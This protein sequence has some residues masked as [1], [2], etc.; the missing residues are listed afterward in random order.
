MT[1][2]AVKPAR[3]LA[4]TAYQKWMEAQEIPIHGGYGVFDVRTVER[5]PWKL[6]GTPGAFIE[7]IGMEGFSGMQVVEI[8][9]GGAILPQKHMFQQ[10]ICGIEG[11]GTAEVWLDEA[12]EQKLTFEWGPFSLFSPPLNSSY[13]LY[14]VGNTPVIYLAVND[15]PMM[16]DLFHNLDFIFNNPYVFRD[17]FTGDDAEYFTREERF[18]EGSGMI[19]DTNF[20][21]DVQNALVDALDAKGAGVK[22]TIFDM[23]KN[24]FA[25]HLTEWPVGRYHKS[26]HHQ[27]GAIL[28]IAR[29]TGYS[30]MWPQEL[31]VRPYEN[32]FDDQI[33]RIEW[34][35][36]SVFSPPTKWFHQHFNTGDETA[37]QLAFRPGGSHNN[38]TGFRRSGSRVVKGVPGVYVSY[39]EGG[40]LIEYE[41]EDPQIKIDFE[42][43]LREV[44]IESKMPDFNYN[45]DVR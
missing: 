44:G 18:L 21:D 9:P 23:A 8:P 35:P 19:W 6:T 7:L 14:N 4:R 36:Y 1:Q 10:L 30:L 22:I 26:H 12:P 20:I 5:K 16:I 31:G 25:G 40:T 39:R 34:G 32:K 41:D 17:R 13:R 27:G 42:A 43:K 37:R 33:V 15:A 24:S 38:P 28:L 11:H 29:S 2:Q 45:S 3:G